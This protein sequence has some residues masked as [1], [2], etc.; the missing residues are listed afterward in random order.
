MATLDD[1]LA[2]LQAVLGQLEDDVKAELANVFQAQG[3]SG[4]GLSSW[5]NASK[6]LVLAELPDQVTPI[7]QQLNAAAAQVSATWYDELAPTEPYL[8]EVPDLDTLLPTEKVLASIS[9]AVNTATTVDTALAQMQKAMQRHVLDGSRNTV[10]HNAKK[11]NVKY[12]RHANYAGVCNWC[13]V[14]ATKGAVYSSASAALASHDN[15]KCFAVPIRKG[16]D[17]KPPAIVDAAQKKYVQAQKNLAA[18]GLNS[19]NLDAIV[20]EMDNIDAAGV[21]KAKPDASEYAKLPPAQKKTV[22]NSYQGKKNKAK[23]KFGDTSVEY[24]SLKDM[25]SD[26]YYELIYKPEHA[27]VTTAAK[28]T[29]QADVVTKQAQWIAAEAK[30]NAQTAMSQ[31]AKVEATAAAQSTAKASAYAANQA[32]QKVAQ[33]AAQQAAAVPTNPVAEVSKPPE[34][35]FGEFQMQGSAGGSHGAVFMTGPDPTA[36][37]FDAPVKYVVKPQKHYKNLLDQT[38]S[39]L[40]HKTGLHAPNVWTTNEIPGLAEASVQEFLPGGNAYKPQIVGP[41]DLAVG[42]VLQ[43]QKNQVFDWLIANHDTHA[44]QWVR[45]ASGA[46]VGVDKGQAMKWLGKDKLDWTFHPNKPSGEHEPIYNTLWTMG[47]EGKVKLADPSAPGALHDYIQGVQAIPDAEYKDLLRPFAEAAAKDGKLLAATDGY[48][49]LPK[50]PVASNDVDAFLDLAVARKNNLQND[51]DALYAKYM[52]QKTGVSPMAPPPQVVPQPTPT[53]DFDL[54]SKTKLEWT[55][56]K[57][58]DAHKNAKNG[59][60]LSAMAS[61][62]NAASI[63][64][65]TAEDWVKTLAG[66]NQMQAAKLPTTPA[67]KALLEHQKAAYTDVLNLLDQGAITP[68]ALASPGNIVGIAAK[69]AENAWGMSEAEFANLYPDK[70]HAYAHPVPAAAVQPSDYFK[71]PPSVKKTVQNSYSGKKNKAKVKYGETSP[72]FLELKAMGPDG[73]Y[74]KVYATNKPAAQAVAPKVEP[75]PAPA[76]TPA[77]PAGPKQIDPE[78][79]ALVTTT[80][81]QLESV[82]K[83]LDKDALYKVGNQFSG[84]KA[85]AKKGSDLESKT[86]AHIYSTWSKK[87][88]WAAQ[89]LQPGGSLPHP[90]KNADALALTDLQAKEY[91]L[92][93]D[94]ADDWQATHAGQALVN[95]PYHG[96]EQ[97]LKWTNANEYKD[98]L[99]KH[100]QTSMLGSPL[101]GLPKVP[102]TKVPTTAPPKNPPND[103]G[104]LAKIDAWQ[105]DYLANKPGG[106]GFNPVK[107]YD[108][109]GTLKSNIE[110]FANDIGVG[111]LTED[112]LTQVL[113]KLSAAQKT[114]YLKQYADAKGQAIADALT[115]KINP[116]GNPSMVSPPTSAG[117]KP[118]MGSSI[119]GWK[120]GITLKPGTTHTPVRVN[121]L[122]AVTSLANPKTGK[123]FAV[124]DPSAPL[125]SSDNPH[126]FLKSDHSDYKTFGALITDQDADAWVGAHLQPV[127]AYTGASY[128]NYNE[129]L[130]VELQK[131]M[132]DWIDPATNKPKL[133]SSGKPLPKPKPSAKIQ[134]IDKA[135]DDPVALT[136]EEWM[137]ITR[138]A[139]QR[140]FAD[141]TAGLSITQ[142]GYNGSVESLQPLVGKEYTQHGIGSTSITTDPAFHKHVRVIYRIPPGSKMLY[143]DG[144]PSGGYGSAISNNSG[145]REIL[146]PRDSR[147]KVLE[148][149]ESTMDGLHIDVVVELVEQ[150]P[151]G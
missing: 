67:G 69:K 141:N 97:M 27:A 100:G 123:N 72:E 63:N 52:T 102:G 120:A 18:Q 81:A 36:G 136:N 58:I 130:R 59:S 29:A 83:L 119:N 39:D 124:P 135:F 14:M 41:H 144:T 93:K 66:S 56:L 68:D 117:S 57:V 147:Y 30:F 19:G 34:P 64:N 2:A 89:Q 47:L 126:V 25:G 45:D 82:Y 134:N 143:V 50:Y 142:G 60:K 85:K 94:L 88:Y 127:K 28:A 128:G 116:P 74:A 151:L 15:C 71:L 138:G 84:K 111:Y 3:Y 49:L 78:T 129:Q 86:V 31:A 145:E 121:S 23:A 96:I 51:F 106:T 112:Q 132:D 1:Q 7:V 110:P 91:K 12:V 9:W 109:S 103:L 125:G 8:A 65:L 33:E 55:V 21:A 37:P 87:D 42:D 16:V 38:T 92:A 17:Y 76:P 118:S 22:Q 139:S 62:K 75:T 43:L 137:I 13:L 148:V 114:K 150:E 101:S 73:Y 140:E 95:N 107:S 146:L 90:Y 20:K 32:A 105:A 5:D 53:V 4:G 46:L 122:Q 6:G 54:A 77:A 115:L 79:D 44:Q 133:D 26:G 11:E 24:T 48:D 149:R 108:P 104:K 99:L 70:V 10:L 61:L 35:A 98:W 131:M 80:A 40:A 113:V